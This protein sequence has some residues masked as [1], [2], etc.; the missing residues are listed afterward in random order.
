MMQKR[1]SE[2]SVTPVRVVIITLD[3]H[4]SATVKRANTLLHRRLPNL[5]LTLHAA[6]SWSK[7]PDSLARC[8][9][10]I[11]KG[12][13][14][15]VTMMF[16]EDHI[17]A[18]L[19]ALQ[20]RRE[21]CDAMV[22]CMS[23]GEIVRLTRMGRFKMGEKDS[24]AIELLKRLRGSKKSGS[25]DGAK[26]MAVL[27]R[28]PRM[29]RFIPG[30]AQDLRAYFLT[31]QYWLACSDENLINMVLF[32]IDRYSTASNKALRGV[33]KP[34]LPVTYPDTGLYHPSLADRTSENLHDLPKPKAPT[35]TIGVI[36]MRAY[37]LAGDTSH[38]D[39]VIKALEAKGLRVI[40]VFACGLDSR[41]AIT[42]FFFANGKPQVDAVLSLTGFSLV[43][44]PAY[45]NAQAA[46]EMLTEL[47]VPYIS[48]HA[49][50]FQTVEE[51]RESERGLL[52]VEAT[53]MVAIPELDGA[54]GS[55]I[56]G[57]RSVSNASEPVM[58]AELERA[59]ALVDRAYRMIAMRRTKVADRKIAITLFNF[60]PN[61]GATGTA[62]FLDV[63]GSL[64][65]VLNSLKKHGYLVDVP[66]SVDA[67]RTL[68]LEGNAKQF[69]SDANVMARIPVDDHVRQE[70]YLDE[71]EA[72]WGTAP[73]KL[74]TDGST[75]HVLGASFGNVM[76]GIQ[77]GFGYEGD[78]MRLL[79]DK[80]FAPTHA[81]S[82]YYRY[83]R[84]DFGADAVLHF[85]THGALEFMP[86][87][88]AGL[89]AD[90]WPDRLIGNLP[91]F[92][93]YAANNPSEGLIAKRR[94]LATLISY[95]TPPVQKAGLYKDLAD[96]K[97]SIDRWRALPP[98]QQAERARLAQLIQSQAAMIDMTPASPLW[99]DAGEAEVPVVHDALIELQNTLIPH[100]L[101]ILGQ[102]PSD[103]ERQDYIDAMMPVAGDAVAVKPDI[104]R[105]AAALSK[106]AEIPAVLHALDGG[107]IRPV[108]GGDLL[109][110]PDILPTGRNIHGFDPFLIPSPFA[111]KDGARQAEH[112]VAR[113]VADTGTYPESIALVLWGTDNLKNEG[114]P[115]GQAL[116][117][118]GAE[119]RYDS[120]GRV[121]GAKLIDLETLGRPRIDVVMT[122]SGIFRDLLPLHMKMLA[123]AAN[124][125]AN[126]D[127]PLDRNYVRRNALAHQEEYGCDFETASLRVFSNADGAYGSNVNHLVDNGQ[128]EDE[129]DLAEM[130]TQRK[131]FAYS[132]SGEAVRHEE[133]LKGMLGKV[134]LA[135]QNLESLEVGVTTIDHYFDSLGGITRAATQSR[136]ESIPVYIADHTRGDGAIRTLNEQV[137]LETRTRMLNPAWYEGMLK[138][139]YEGV[140]QIEAHVTNT[141]GWSATTGQV[142]P[143]IYRQLTETFVMDPEMRDRLSAL[144]VQ[145]SA[146]VVNR[147]LEAH[148]R[149]YWQPDD[150]MLEALREAG[151]EMEDKLEGV[152]GEMA[153]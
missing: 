57:G 29:L 138:H 114:T 38:Y 41:P 151:D 40:P 16:M 108:A 35:G 67:L 119:P 101:H 106:D 84:N 83:L 85:G 23:S 31:M 21:E 86:G 87:K 53:M 135:Y 42:K 116:S 144:N 140:R 24:G 99:D 17:N 52:P 62:A 61:S 65:N 78:P 139:G 8:R 39:T 112:L 30:T 117:L 56:Y 129:N 153:A 82:A 80:G 11:A 74:Q 26:Q 47:D 88:Q 49:L 4:L 45:N 110:N 37:V 70:P 68:L 91:N 77:P 136:G 126:A 94:S 107:F 64:F 141:V 18:V 143:W 60:P 130:F 128:W 109:R 95:L 90:C 111:M 75:I 14:I 131:C 44:G 51:W 118:I 96:L 123:E 34:A 59:N 13:I 148:E 15:I 132:Q 58:A 1:T 46:E 113:H 10:D 134:N 103:A 76:V 5:Q 71:I 27:R 146:R 20:A 100:G 127:E 104:E 81:F 33:L 69:G 2:D 120:F 98:E 22:C 25:S 36:L 43:G 147:L 93:I 50:E 72:Q 149:N 122:V 121:A 9:N 152:G 3:N 115:I 54:I 97:G 150:D 137:A 7:N 89:S 125:A 73:G 92:Y 12:D 145:A 48:A 102:A 55:A 19:P 28:L 133:L 32:L 124:L 66:D 105:I 63:F 142:D 6:S 79:F